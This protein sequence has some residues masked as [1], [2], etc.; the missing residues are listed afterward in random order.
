MA[1]SEL[2]P[3]NKLKAL[4]TLFALSNPLSFVAKQPHIHGEQSYVRIKST[5]EPFLTSVLH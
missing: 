5:P 2:G 3:G 1:G 4:L